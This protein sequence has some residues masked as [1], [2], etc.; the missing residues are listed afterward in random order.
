MTLNWVAPI[1]T[2]LARDLK[3]YYFSGPKIFKIITLV[4]DYKPCLAHRCW[5]KHDLLLKAPH[6]KWWIYHTLKFKT[7]VTNIITPPLRFDPR[8][9]RPL[10]YRLRVVSNFGDCDCGAGKIHTR[11]RKFEETL[12]SRRVSSKFRARA[13]V[14]CPPH[15][16]HRQN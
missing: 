1:I 9:K 12:P 4:V 13:C 3:L 11:A 5:Q 6:L 7:F 2:S 8:S 10:T 14:F 15:N 16:R